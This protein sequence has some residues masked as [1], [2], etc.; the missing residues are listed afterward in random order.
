[1]S[2][3]PE[4]ELEDREVEWVV[5]VKHRYYI[6]EIQDLFFAII[7]GVITGV[8]LILGSNNNYLKDYTST[9]SGIGIF[10]V[11]IYQ[12]SY[13]HRLD[14][15]IRRDEDTNISISVTNDIE[16]YVTT[17]YPYLEE[18]YPEIQ[19]PLPSVPDIVKKER[20]QIHFANIVIRHVESLMSR[21]KVF[22]PYYD[23]WIS[24][25]RSWFLSPI[26]LEIW[27]HTR[28]IYPKELQVFIDEQ[29]IK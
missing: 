3:L 20:L 17:N 5:D 16:G 6:Y 22:P 11:F 18:M 29:V 21:D 12:A 14:D 28:D 15:E 25:M 26:L 10:L 24:T 27:S 4:K 7:L 1:M 9:I 8:Y 13:Q 2:S 19:A 23:K